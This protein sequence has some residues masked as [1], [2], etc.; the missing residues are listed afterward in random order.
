MTLTEAIGVLTVKAQSDPE[1]APV[2]AALGTNL[3]TLSG[4]LDSLQS[5]ASQ[6]QSGAN[7]LLA[8][9]TALKAGTDTLAMEAEK[10][11]EGSKSLYD[12]T[13]QLESGT[14]TLNSGSSQIKKGLSTLNGG[15]G[16]LLEAN[17]GL[18]QGAGTLSN[19]AK[20]LAD[21][22]TKFDKEGVGAICSY[23]NGDLK[24]VSVRLEKLQ[25]LADEY[26]NFTAIDDTAT[27]NIK[28][29]MIIDS[30]KASDETKEHATL[31]EKKEENN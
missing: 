17:N 2:V 22:M 26:N 3:Q 27:G 6:I 11:A 23:L 8:G 19:G 7:E 12:G 16:S 5:G 10:L 21:G 24:D 25:E 1:L 29:I 14:K 30:I 15:C 31:N 20:T 13:L 18:T 28:F 4:A 9:E